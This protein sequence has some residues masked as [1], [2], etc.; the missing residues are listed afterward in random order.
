[1]MNIEDI[2][3]IM[4][5]M[6][7]YQLTEFS[8]EAD[9]SNISMRREGS[10]SA[11]VQSIP[12]AVAIPAPVAAPAPAPAASAAP[13]AAPAAPGVTVESP[14]VG[15][16]YAAPSPDAAPFIQV[17]DRV[18]PDTVIG[19]IEAMKVMNEIKAE[20]SGVVREIVAQ[21]GQPVEY[22]QVL[23]VLE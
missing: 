23:I 16:F 2:K 17:G 18:T 9:G 12:Q 8:V 11:V 6:A 4:K 1:M 3:T 21:N 5:L 19:I 14:L 15:T 13:A 7:E 10:V 20:K 22:G